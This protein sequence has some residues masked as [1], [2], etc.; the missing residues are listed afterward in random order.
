MKIGIDCFPLQSDSRLRGIGRYSLGLVRALLAEPR[1]HDFL[2]YIRQDLN[3]ENIPSSRQF[4]IGP[5]GLQPYL[6]GNP[7]GLDAILL[8]SPH[9]SYLTA[10]CKIPKTAAIVYDLIPDRMPELF[11]PITSYKVQYEAYLDAARKYDLLLAISDFT[12]NDFLKIRKFPASKVITVG[13][14]IDR[15]FWSPAPEGYRLGPGMFPDFLRR[16]GVNPPYVLH[17]GG[18][19]PRK[20]GKRLIEAWSHVAH[21]IRRPCQLVYAYGISLHHQHE[22]LRCA[23]SRGISGSQFLTA[24][25]LGD[26]ALRDLYR[27]AYVH[28]LPS[29]AEGLGL[30]HVEAIACGCPSIGLANTSQPEA[31]GDAG[32]CVSDGSTKG[33]AATL[34]MVLGDRDLRAR[35]AANC[36]GQAA[37]FD[38]ARVAGRVLDAMEG[39]LVGEEGI[40]PAVESSGPTAK[41]RLAIFGPLPPLMSG[42][43]PYTAGLARALDGRY[44]V[45][46]FHDP[47]VSIDPL[48]DITV[49]PANEFD[50]KRWPLR[51][52]Q[53]GNNPLHAYMVETARKHP[54]VV[55][56][57]DLNLEGIEDELNWH[58]DHDIFLIDRSRLVESLASISKAVIIHS[59]SVTNM[60]PGWAIDKIHVAPFGGS[61]LVLTEEEKIKA[62]LAAYLPTQRKIVCVPGI[63]HETKLC[64]EILLTFAAVE[65]LIPG[66]CL[67]FVG[68]DGDGGDTHELAK[69]MKI[70][71]PRCV[72]TGPLGA[73][74]FAQGMAACDLAVCL[75]QHPTNGEWSAALTDALRSGVPSIVS[76]V[77][78]FTEIPD[79]AVRFVKDA[80]D[81]VKALLDLCR[82]DQA[83][84][85]LGAAGLAYAKEHLA[86]EKTAESYARALE[87]R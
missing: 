15:S 47:A 82:D 34:E 51:S 12:R 4:A 77:G 20:G 8:L 23:S 35:L 9:E 64:Q 52:Y 26:E 44:D 32:L 81:L 18:E 45:T 76:P 55:T 69:N 87:D 28:C 42:I 40:A 17:V 19:C 37:K 57:H 65:P 61:P 33:I 6:A 38:W 43:S 71:S 60:L 2:L 31:I 67:A 11:Q 49:L 7:T 85:K 73:N 78:T 48:P 70:N 25:G 27:F 22:L 58:H 50:P 84:T 13:C 16:L 86:W 36:A 79:D 62:R 54:G 24:G 72:F 59:A 10:R 30:P 29:E 21:P 14:G 74:V 56:L 66:W 3:R 39:Q 41:P 80:K 83:R 75:R 46:V 63:I 5:G 53:I 68:P 1:G